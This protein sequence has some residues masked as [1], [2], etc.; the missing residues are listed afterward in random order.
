MVARRETEHARV[1]QVIAGFQILAGHFKAGFFDEARH[2]VAICFDIAIAGFGGFW[3]DAEGDQLSLCRQSH[4]LSNGQGKR[5]L[6]GNQMIGGQYQQQRVITL[7]GRHVQ[8]SRSNG[9]SCVAAKGFEDEIIGKVLVP[10]AGNLAILVLGLEEELAVGN[11]QSSAT[12][13]RDTPR[14]QAFCSR[15]WPSARRSK[16][17]RMQLAG[18]R[19]SLNL[20]RHTVSSGS[21]S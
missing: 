8:C 12:S 2:L 1:P 4:C 14:S 15:L 18:N 10:G 19:P 16:R 3:L 21:I 20:L 13:G 9:G 5:G 17:L 7:A 6:I 11:G